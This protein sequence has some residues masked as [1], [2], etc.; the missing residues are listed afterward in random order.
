[1][2][3]LIADDN[4]FDRQ[5]LEATLSAW[6]FSVLSAC[7]GEAAWCLLRSMRGPRLVLLDWAMPVLDGLQLCWKLRG[8]PDL[9]PTYIMMLTARGGKENIVRAL[10]S[11]ADDFIQKPIER[12]QLYTRLVVAL[13]K[14]E[15]ALLDGL[16]ALDSDHLPLVVP[17]AEVLR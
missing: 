7:D 15:P 11:G 9:P 17:A 8:V 13:S 1:M 5:L 4:Q 3:V 6:G 14:L 12:E 2:Q 16:A 10:Q